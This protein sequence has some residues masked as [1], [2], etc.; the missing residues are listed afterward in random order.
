M[1]LAPISETKG[2]TNHGSN[3][4]ERQC[5]DQQ[6]YLYREEELAVRDG[7]S[8]DSRRRFSKSRILQ[9]S[10]DAALNLR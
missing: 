10:I 4:A 1:A 8:F 7:R 5:G 2:K 9:S 3:A 6:S